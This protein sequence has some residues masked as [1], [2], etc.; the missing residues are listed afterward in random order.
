M[1]DSPHNPP[2]SAKDKRT[3]AA[4]R[5][6]LGLVGRRPWCRYLLGRREARLDFYDGRVIVLNCYPADSKKVGPTRFYQRARRPGPSTLYRVRVT[7]KPR[8]AK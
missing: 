6:R 8:P 4:L 5:G 7:P 2:Y 1:T 3:D